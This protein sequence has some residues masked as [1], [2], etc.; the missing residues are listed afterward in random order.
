MESPYL[1]VIVS[2]W[3]SKVASHGKICARRVLT[4]TWVGQAKRIT[5]VS[6]SLAHPRLGCVGVGAESVETKA[7]GTATGLAKVGGPLSTLNQNR[8]PQIPVQGHSGLTL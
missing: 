7:A 1:S 5:R 4:Q 2:V 8:A 6:Q 3:C